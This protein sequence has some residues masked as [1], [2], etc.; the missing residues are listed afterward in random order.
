V[1]FCGEHISLANIAINRAI[2][3][4]R[5]LDILALGMRDAFGSVSHFQLCNNFQKLCL[6]PILSNIIVDRNVDARV[7]IVL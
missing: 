4:K 6:S 1:N 2:T 5:T 7:K 3:E